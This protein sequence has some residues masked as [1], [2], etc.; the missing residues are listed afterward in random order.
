MLYLDEE[1]AHAFWNTELLYLKQKLLL[2]DRKLLVGIL[3]KMAGNIA[4]NITKCPLKLEDEIEILCI[5]IAWTLFIRQKLTNTRQ[6]GQQWL[7][8]KVLSIWETNLTE[9]GKRHI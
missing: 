8:R 2:D 9:V 4:G 7:R 3:K 5:W 1:M 6:G